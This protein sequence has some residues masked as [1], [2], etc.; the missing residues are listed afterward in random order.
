VSFT[1]TS[2]LLPGRRSCS[3]EVDAR[4]TEG[5]TSIS[6]RREPTISYTFRHRPVRLRS[7]RPFPR[8]GELVASIVPSPVLTT[9][10]HA[11]HKERG[12]GR[13]FTQVGK[14]VE[15]VCVDPVNRSIRQLLIDKMRVPRRDELVFVSGQVIGPCL[16]EP[17]VARR[18][19]LRMGQ[20]LGLRGCSALASRESPGAN[21]GPQQDRCHSD[22]SKRNCSCTAAWTTRRRRSAQQLQKRRTRRPHAARS[23]RD[24]EAAKAS[25]FSAACEYFF[26]TEVVDERADGSQVSA[27]QRGFAPHLPR[28]DAKG[29][30]RGPRCVANSLVD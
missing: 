9:L 1:G 18:R 29:P 22:A 17:A 15:A 27:G 13:A 3:F 10:P 28:M 14:L 6:S 30:R 26:M 7:G 25:E 8:R 23:R 2:Q 5:G 24:S 20:Y 4:G 19:I 16:V 12:H 21:R 11:I